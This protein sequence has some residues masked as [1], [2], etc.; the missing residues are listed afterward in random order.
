VQWESKIVRGKR[1]SFVAPHG[2]EAHTRARVIDERDG[3]W[4]WELQPLTGR[5][6][7]L[8]VEM[9]RFGAPIFGD[10]LYGGEAAAVKDWIALRAV[11]L[12][13]AGIPA[14]ER[15]DLDAELCV[16]PLTLPS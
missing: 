13:F 6:H 4:L 11:S 7:Q 1:R 9:A 12:S 3:F 16:E 10:T 8:R 5:P 2:Q 14:A 15:F